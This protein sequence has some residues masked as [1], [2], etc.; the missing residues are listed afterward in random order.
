MIDKTYG[1][2]RI[3][4]TSDGKK[5]IWCIYMDTKRTPVVRGTV[6]H[7]KSHAFRAA[8]TYLKQMI[9]TRMRNDLSLLERL[10]GK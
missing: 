8:A 7:Y 5:W 10:D 3:K 1:E 4:L 6:H 9:R 2:F